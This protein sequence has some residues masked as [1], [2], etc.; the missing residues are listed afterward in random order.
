LRLGAYWCAF[1]GTGVAAE[2]PP[3]PVAKPHAPSPLQRARQQRRKR[4]RAGKVSHTSGPAFLS[5]F[6]VAVIVMALAA[7]AIDSIRD[8]DSTSDRLD[9]ADFR[10]TVAYG[11]PDG[12]YAIRFPGTSATGAVDRLEQVEIFT[13]PLGA[14]PTETAS[15]DAYGNVYSVSVVSLPSTRGSDADVAQARCAHI[16]AAGTPLPV[17]AAGHAAWTCRADAGIGSVRETIV[18][19][20]DKA[21][22]VRGEES[23]TLL[24]PTYADLVA[25]LRIPGRD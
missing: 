22:V 8:D 7:G 16:G 10:E 6:V 3:T 21:V 13:T 17:E 2:S 23:V 25:S 1:C 19:V 18:F 15:H 14:L 9:Q 12:V 5:W 11:D 4:R 20:D 24:L